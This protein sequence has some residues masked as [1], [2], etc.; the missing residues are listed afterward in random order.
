LVHEAERAAG[1]LA[2]GWE[3]EA[4]KGDNKLEIDDEIDN[5]IEMDETDQSTE[6]AP[7]QSA[8]SARPEK[9]SRI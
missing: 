7:D 1:G 3:D 8:A 6:A 4:D 9:L 5:E 2:G